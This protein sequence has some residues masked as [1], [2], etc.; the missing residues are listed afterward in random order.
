MGIKELPPEVKVH[1]SCDTCAK[2]LI[3]TTVKG[4]QL[5]GIVLPN[6]WSIQAHPPRIEARTY[7]ETYE[8]TCP[9]CNQLTTK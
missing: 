1:V 7:I 2:S 4:I 8:V 3:V 9:A 6:G 5:S